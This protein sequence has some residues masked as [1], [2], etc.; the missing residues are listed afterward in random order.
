MQITD[1]RINVR[2][3]GNFIGYADIVLDDE[4]AIHGLKIIKGPKGIFVSM[5]HKEK[6]D[7]QYEDIVHPA[8]Q[9]TREWITKAVLKVYRE[10]TEGM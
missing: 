10:K 6:E 3:Q 1:I 9:E 2:P 7:G 8:N 5:P 4:L